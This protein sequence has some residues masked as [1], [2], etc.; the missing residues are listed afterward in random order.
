MGTARRPDDW[1]A[2]LIQAVVCPFEA[3]ARHGVHDFRSSGSPRHFVLSPRGHAAAYAYR[4]DVGTSRHLRYEAAQA[5]WAERNRLELADGECLHELSLGRS[6][7]AEL[8]EGVAIHGQ[9][10]EMVVAT[11]ARLLGRGLAELSSREDRHPAVPCVATMSRELADAEAVLTQQ[12]RIVP[13]TVEGAPV[14]SKRRGRLIFTDRYDGA[15][16]MIDAIN[17]VDAA[18]RWLVAHDFE[19]AEAAGTPAGETA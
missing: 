4:A 6:T 3:P 8:A 9:T 1:R 11:L 7:S 13:R 5:D 17:R 10:G 15:H 12:A 18:R 2:T 19:Q 16:P 14:V